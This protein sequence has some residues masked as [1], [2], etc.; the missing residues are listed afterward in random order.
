MLDGTRVGRR[1]ALSP[2]TL[3]QVLRWISAWYAARRGEG[4]CVRACVLATARV[5]DGSMAQAVVASVDGEQSPFGARRWLA[6]AER[7]R[8]SL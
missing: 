4:E 3:P 8:P 7:V 5:H 1:L 6:H 2:P